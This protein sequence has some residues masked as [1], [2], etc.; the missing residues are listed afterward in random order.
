M[1]L[2]KINEACE[3]VSWLADQANNAPREHTKKHTEMA[4]ALVMAHSYLVEYAVHLSEGKTAAKA[5]TATALGE[6]EISPK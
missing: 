5:L 2:E 6:L 4:C 3:V 1:E